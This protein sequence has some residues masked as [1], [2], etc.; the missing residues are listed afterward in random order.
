MVYLRYADD[1]LPLICEGCWEGEIL[2]A[3]RGSNGFGYDPLFY[4]PALDCTS[5]ELSAQEKNRLSHRGRALHLLV[6]R[7]TAPCT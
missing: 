1:P 3:P 7:L 5:A 2:T 6:E 4:L